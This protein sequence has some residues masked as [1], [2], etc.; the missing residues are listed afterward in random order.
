M[1]VTDTEKLMY[2]GSIYLFLENFEDT[3][4]NIVTAGEFRYSYTR[5][6]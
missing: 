6:F 2:A 3:F 1:Q 4:K 5:S